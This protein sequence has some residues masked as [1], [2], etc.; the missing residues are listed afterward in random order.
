MSQAADAD[1]SQARVTVR[2]RPSAIWLV[3]LV[4]VLIAAWLVWTTL[5]SRGPL[6]TITFESAE[7]LQAG[8]SQVKYKDVVM[9][10]VQSVTVAPDLTHVTVIARMTPEAEPLL[11]ER[12]KF[13]VVRP[14]LSAGAI[15]GLETLLSGSYIA[16]LPS[17]EKGRAQRSFT[18]LEDPPVLQT[19]VPGHTFLLKATRIGSIS[20]GSPLFFRGLTVGEVLGWDV[21]DMAESVTIHAF[22]RAPYDR[23]VH[24][25]T[26]FWNASGISLQFGGD[27]VRLRIESLRAVLL[28][29][30]AFETPSR[31]TSPR[32][33]AQDAVFPLFADEAAAEGAGYSRRIQ[34]VAYFPGAVDGLAKG[35]PVTL[36]GIRIGE[37]T[38]LSLEYD[39]AS[40]SLRVPVHFEIEPERIA[41]SAEAAGRGPLAN[42]TRLVGQGL[43]A[44]LQ[45]TNLLT[46]Q[47]SIA[48]TFVADAPPAEVKIENGAF[49]VPTVPDQIAGI[50]EAAQGLIGK[51]EKVPFDRIG[52]N[53]NATLAGTSTLVNSE[54]LRQT[55]ISLQGTVG[56]AQTFMKGLD[57][58]AAPAL[59]R[60]PGIAAG[61][62]ESVTRLN[63]L[64]LGIDTGYG[65]NSRIYRNIDRLLAQ[66]N[67]T[68]Q[69]VRVLSDILARHPEAILRGRPDVGV[70][71]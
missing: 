37:V 67:D 36:R 24:E 4:A 22:V 48:F 63:R 56:A 40:D 64:M 7:G 11:N 1:S 29:G 50:V 25:E 58:A 54:A 26:R 39:R 60:L 35:A 20:A 41:D 33:T 68:A 59:Q 46:G 43:R 62:Q 45:T 34:G 66:L 71:K 2:Q 23:Y 14:R 69:A 65:E 57:S 49:V 55:L 31:P 9:G 6:I 8:Q 47:K 70:T 15:S 61:L 5:S 12:A 19:T 42:L 10:T 52:E 3:P 51:L 21:A 32:V 38:G 30:I 16:I 44:Q 13:W 17:A 18:G 28:G 27:G 53:I